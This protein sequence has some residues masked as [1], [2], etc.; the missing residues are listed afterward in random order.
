MGNN[1]SLMSRDYLNK[2]WISLEASAKFQRDCRRL[3]FD[4]IMLFVVKVMVPAFHTDWFGTFGLILNTDKTVGNNF[5]LM[6][7]DYLRRTF[8]GISTISNCETDQS[9]WKRLSLRQFKKV[10]H[11]SHVLFNICARLMMDRKRWCVEADGGAPNVSIIQ[12]KF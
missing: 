3:T 10:T 12:I 7:R 8:E 4:K 6:S 9:S 2:L 5:S 11:I 1:F